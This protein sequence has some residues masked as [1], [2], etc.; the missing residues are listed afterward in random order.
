MRS[1]RV[2]LWWGAIPLL[3][4]MGF[5]LILQLFSLPINSISLE[6]GRKTVGKI[7]MLNERR[8]QGGLKK[9]GMALTRFVL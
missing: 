7:I 3:A 2:L 5:Q 6:S 8:V 9:I 1:R 4:C